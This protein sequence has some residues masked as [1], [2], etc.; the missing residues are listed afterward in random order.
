MSTWKYCALL[1]LSLTTTAQAADNPQVSIQFGVEDFRWREF[2][3]GGER[4]L[5]ETGWR[6]SIG[7]AYDNFRREGPGLLYS[8]GGKLYLGVVDYDGQTQSGIPATADVDYF[9]VTIE[10]LAGYRFGRR[11]GLDLFGGI[12]FDDWLRSINNGRTNTGLPVYGYDEYYTILYGKA[13]LGFFQLL[14]SWRYMLQAGVK[15]P[16]ITSE[17]VDL[18]GGITLEPGI[19]PAA[20]ANVQFDFGSGRHNRFSVTLYYDGYRFSASDPERVS[21]TEVVWQ[22]RSH[23]DVYGLRFGY[24]FF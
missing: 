21:A 9:G 24:Y 18:D 20:F 10:A 13:G 3:D 16:L 12:G 15:L 2:G 5:Q 8:V 7:A 14:N 17:Y 11:L 19:E 1:F 4:L 6:Y 22:P 23:M